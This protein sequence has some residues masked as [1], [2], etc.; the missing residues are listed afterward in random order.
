ML[1][2]GGLRLSPKRVGSQW[3]RTLSTGGCQMDRLIPFLDFITTGEYKEKVERGS[4]SQG[5]LL[6]ASIPPLSPAPSAA[7][8]SGL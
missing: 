7:D 8:S 5:G 6:L 1:D 2:A 3:S 4:L